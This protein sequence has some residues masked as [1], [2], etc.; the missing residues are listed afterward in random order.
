MKPSLK[1]AFTLI[2]LLVVIAIIA[3]LAALLLPALSRAKWKAKQISC[4]NN[5]KQMGIGSQ[6]YANDDPR[7][8]LSGVDWNGPQFNAACDDDMNWLFP[9]FLPNLKSVTCPDTQNFIRT[10]DKRGRNLAVRVTDRR[11]IE[12]LHGQKEIYTDLQRFAADK[13]TKPGISYEIFGCMNWNGVPNRRYTKGFPYVGPTGCQG[14][15]KTESVVSNYVHA[16]S[17]FGLKGHV[18]GPSEIWLIKEADY[19]YPGAMNNYPD[20]GDNHGA[21]GENVLFVDAHVEFIKRANYNYSLELGND[22]LHYGPR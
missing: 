4:I 15:L 20:E 1:K 5:E 7:G 17:G 12:R 21:E 19:S 11:Y 22:A 18:T 6:S 3:I 13:G 16:N 9:A 2:E 8:V 14:I 10:Q